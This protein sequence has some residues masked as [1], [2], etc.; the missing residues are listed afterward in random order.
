MN[1]RFHQ[2]HVNPVFRHFSAAMACV[3]V[4]L[5]H[6]A[7]PS[8][9]AAV[10]AVFQA[11]AAKASLIPPFPTP[12]GG[13]TDRLGTFTG[14]ESPVYARALVCDNGSTRLAVVST[15]LV[16]VSREVVDDARRRIQESTGIPGENVLVCATHTHSGPAAME[17]SAVFAQEQVDQLADFLAGAIATA[18]IDAHKALAPAR[19]SFASGRLDNITTNRQQK[20]DVVIDPEVGVLKVQKP[21][22]REVIAVLFNFTGHPVILG[23]DNLQLSSEYIG[24]AE[25]TVESLLGGVA[26]FTQGA[27]GDVTVKRSGPPVEEVKRLGR[28]LGAEVIK[29]AETAAPA[30]ESV[31]VSAFEDVTLE[32]RQVP[33]VA[34]AQASVDKL[35]ANLDAAKAAGQPEDKLRRLNRDGDAAETLL[36]V[37]KAAAERPETLAKATQA[38]VQV[39]QIG[40]VVL[41]GVP[42]ELFVEYGLEMKQRVR[43]DKN[44]PMLLVGYANGYNGYF[45]S[46]RATYTG[47][48]EQAVARV[49][50]SGGRTLTEAAMRLVD[51]HIPPP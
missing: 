30:D 1:S 27:C 38:S 12:M 36:A 19:L 37:A 49:A 50:P 40:P 35:Q 13:F 8:D 4:A 47:G 15:A 22:S 33:T 14:V 51:E 43:Q 34:E 5:C 9:A 6:F 29:T 18:V 2:R 11:G 45:V 3:V 44:R 7:G 39:V 41:V 31:L 25:E 48:Y 32:P 42:G 16:G 28:I 17:P 21:D 24:H 26:L 10:G 20:N 23:S 46:P